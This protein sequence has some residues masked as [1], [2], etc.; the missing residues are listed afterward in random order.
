[1]S[2]WQPGSL[3]DVVRWICVFSCLLSFCGSL[4]II[5]AYWKYPSLRKPARHLLLWLSVSDLGT[6]VIYM[7]TIFG[8]YDCEHCSESVK[9]ITAMLGIFWPTSSFLWTDCIA[10]YIYGAS[11]QKTWVN[12]TKRL[13]FVFHIVSWSIPFVVCL[14]LIVIYY[15]QNDVQFSSE[16]TGGWCWVNTFTNQ[17][18]G[19][20]IIEI[21][22]YCFLAVIYFSTYWKLRKIKRLK[23]RQLLLAREP[24]RED[25]YH[26][27]RSQTHFDSNATKINELLTRLT[28]IPLIFVIL[29]SFGT[30]RVILVAANIIPQNGAV[31]NVLQLGQAFCDPLQG[32]C[33]AVLFLLCVSAVR[34]TI[35]N[36][37]SHHRKYRDV[38][39]TT[40]TTPVTTD[41]DPKETDT[42]TITSLSSV[43]HNKPNPLL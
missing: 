43:F 18:I 34:D 42:K 24:Q 25:V 41:V 21:F 1:M 14:I 4:F 35:F 23:K 37:Q 10:I 2:F 29:R 31:D 33:N 19:G 20:K 3:R 17:M 13:F 27:R 39:I 32:F 5:V 6:A 7:G 26:S 8:C 30:L 36:I 40:N 22:S 15:A 11:Y 38:L 28:L 9:L 12:P 16:Y